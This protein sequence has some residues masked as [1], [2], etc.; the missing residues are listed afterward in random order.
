MQANISRASDLLNSYDF[1]IEAEE[2]HSNE[3]DCH[4]VFGMTVSYSST[5]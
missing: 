1:S 5:P 3:K 4:A 2:W